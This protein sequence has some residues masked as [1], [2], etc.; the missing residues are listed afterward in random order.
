MRRL[1]QDSNLSHGRILHG[2]ELVLVLTL[3]LVL[4]L[5]LIRLYSSELTEKVQFLKLN[6]LL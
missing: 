2:G 5:F 1:H 4:F 6:M 3:I